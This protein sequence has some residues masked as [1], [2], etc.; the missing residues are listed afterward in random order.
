VGSLRSLRH[1]PM[2]RNKQGKN[3]RHTWRGLLARR[4]RSRLEKEHPEPLFTVIPGKEGIAVRWALYRHNDKE[5]K[6]SIFKIVSEFMAR[7]SS[8]RP[9]KIKIF[10]SIVGVVIQEAK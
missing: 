1:N 8:Q 9:N 3:S 10:N 6:N 2:A 4:L 7:T 5:I